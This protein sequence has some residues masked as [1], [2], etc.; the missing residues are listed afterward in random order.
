MKK[1]NRIIVLGLLT[2]VLFVYSSCDSFVEGYAVDPN[3]PTDVPQSLLLP[4]AIV[5][6]GSMLGEDL[7][8]YSA[9]F[10]QT[11][12]GI[13]RQMG[14]ASLYNVIASDVGNMWTFT[15][16]AGHMTDLK[17]IID[18]SVENGTS[19]HYA[20]VA[21]ILQA[22]TLGTLVDSWGDVPWTEALKGSENTTPTFDD[23]AFVY[24][25]IQRLLAEG[26][27]DLQG[28]SA[29]APGSD[30]IIF[31]GD[32]GSWI[33]AANALSAR[34]H[35][36]L[37][38]VDPAGSAANA[39]AAIES[40]AIGATSGDMEIPYG[41]ADPQE[42][43]PWYQ[44]NTQR[45]DLRMGSTLVDMM[46]A[47]DD[48]RLPFY[49]APDPDGELTGTPLDPLNGDASELGPF[50]GSINSSMP[51][52]TYYEVKF[53]EAEALLRQGKTADALAAFTEAVTANVTKVTGAAPA[54]EFLD[55]VIPATAGD[56]DLGDI[57][58]QKYIAMFT[59]FESWTDVRRTD[60]PALTPST[61]TSLPKRY[62]YPQR[63]R[64]L[65]GPNVPS[66]NVGLFD[67]LFWDN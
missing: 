31:G 27:S 58:E 35:N 60:F 54:Q 26:I 1:L 45:G 15:I 39:I 4:S 62:P 48:P 53:I 64:D 67:K 12:T 50:Y 29:V 32:A 19:P 24:G 10:I 52:I 2:S 20:G 43:N 8:W 33:A 17:V 51:I 47:N 28:T 13:A 41:T 30:D 63:E 18:K 42:A 38:L 34:Y 55:A 40:G 5:N 25:E 22:V 65:N 16:Y 59:Q 49:A 23:A 9:A 46:K 7:A 44:F 36:H 14:S 61:G 66:G 6:V 3:N 37:S 56:L 11:Q 57:M 21:K